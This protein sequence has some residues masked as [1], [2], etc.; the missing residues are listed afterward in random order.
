L[1]Y[2]IHIDPYDLEDFKSRYLNN[3]EEIAD[4]T[5]ESRRGN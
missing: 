5:L 1:K 2:G 4:V 3:E